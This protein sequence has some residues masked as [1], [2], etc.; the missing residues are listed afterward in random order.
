MSHELAQ[1]HK[2]APKDEPAE[3][4]PAKAA[5]PPVSGCSI[6][7][8]LKSSKA[9]RKHCSNDKNSN[10]YLRVK[11]ENVCIFFYA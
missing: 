7:A 6:P 2:D 10:K 11:M 1:K 9:K 3:T 4:T 8:A 5:H